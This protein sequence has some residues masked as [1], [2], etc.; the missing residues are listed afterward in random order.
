MAY[1]QASR[2]GPPRANGRAWQQE[3]ARAD[4]RMSLPELVSICICM[5]SG[6]CGGCAPSSAGGKRRAAPAQERSARRRAAHNGNRYAQHRSFAD[7]TA[8]TAHLRCECHF[9]EDVPFHLPDVS[10]VYRPTQCPRRHCALAPEGAHS[11]AKPCQ[12]SCDRHRYHLAPTR[13]GSRT[14]LQRRSHMWCAPAPSSAKGLSAQGARADETERSEETTVPTPP[15]ASPTVTERKQLGF[16]RRPDD[17]HTIA[18]SVDKVLLRSDMYHIR[19][20]VVTQ[21]H[22]ARTTFLSIAPS[23]S[24][25]RGLLSPHARAQRRQ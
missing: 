16:A 21:H 4:L 13:H 15:V 20:S 7:V 12:R 11:E 10:P 14:L 22:L 1:V 17:P 25:P 9:V 23:L 2:G 24:T 19:T 8:Y 6:G 3:S 18:R 5:W